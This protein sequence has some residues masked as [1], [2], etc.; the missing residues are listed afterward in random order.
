MEYHKTSSDGMHLIFRD[1]KE[2]K[3]YEKEFLLLNLKYYKQHRDKYGIYAS[4]QDKYVSSIK[5]LNDFDSKY[6]EN[7]LKKYKEEIKS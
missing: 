7:M 3:T 5:E 4:N 6:M 2:L 1:Y